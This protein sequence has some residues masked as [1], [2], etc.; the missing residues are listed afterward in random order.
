M[1]K[2]SVPPP[3]PRIGIAAAASAATG[4]AYLKQMQEQSA[5][6]N[7]WAAEDR[8]RAK[9]FEP[10]QDAYIERAQTWDSPERMDARVNATQA[11]VQGQID[12]AG[13]QRERAMASMGV[14]PNSGKFGAVERTAAL[15][16]GLAVAG[17]GNLERR[18]VRAE[19]DAMQANVINMGAGYQVNP[20]QSMG[21]SNSA[22]GAGNSGAM[23]GYGQQGQVLNT[24]WN[25]RM[26]GVNT[27][28]Q[29]N[30]GFWG[31][32][33]SIVGMA[34]GG[35]FASDKNIKTDKKPVRRSLLDAVAKMPV[36]EWTYKPGEGDGKRHVGPYAQDFKKRTGLGDGKSINVIDIAGVTLGAVKELSEKV[37]ALAGAGRAPARKP[38]RSA[39]RADTAMK[40]SPRRRSIA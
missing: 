15:E 24:Q 26:E 27:H 13:Q 21:L 8:E 40:S 17:A 2:K 1:G 3:D 37:D 29:Q 35:A 12:M 19:A 7:Q 28:N 5:I 23:A 34:A 18:S 25:Q 31:G 38:A 32:V 11:S 4:Q 39:P 10:L 30:A 36:E 20:G 33:G 9:K 14:S 16:G 22:L 6:T